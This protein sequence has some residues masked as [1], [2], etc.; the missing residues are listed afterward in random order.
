MNYL[1]VQLGVNPLTVRFPR[2][3][4]RKIELVN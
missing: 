4:G 3:S 1:G 2:S